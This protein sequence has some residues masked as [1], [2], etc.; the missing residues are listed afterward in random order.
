MKDVFDLKAFVQMVEDHGYGAPNDIGISVG[1][2]LIEERDESYESA[3]YAVV[4]FG[5]LEESDL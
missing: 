5:Y 3:A 1:Q 4:C 2:K